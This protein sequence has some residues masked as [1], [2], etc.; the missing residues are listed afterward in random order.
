MR[1]YWKENEDE[2]VAANADA[3]LGTASCSEGAVS[4]DR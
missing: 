1:S 3:G 2:V 4:V